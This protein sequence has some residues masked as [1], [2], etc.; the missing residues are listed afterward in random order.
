MG[1]AAGER[2][3]GSSVRA[4]NNRTMVLFG[5]IILVQEFHYRR[6]SQSCAAV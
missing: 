3:K 5:E 2:E 1:Q 4:D 6:D